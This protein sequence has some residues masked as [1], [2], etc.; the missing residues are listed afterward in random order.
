VYFS[1]EQWDVSFLRTGGKGGPINPVF[2]AGIY[3]GGDGGVSQPGSN[4]DAGSGGGG[5]IAYNVP[6]K[7]A[8]GGNAAAD[9]SS[10][11]GLPGEDAVYLGSG[12]GG[13]GGGIGDNTPPTTS[14]GGNGGNGAGG[15][16]SITFD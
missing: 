5:A 3:E 9:L 8:N 2:P 14:N 16:I 6:Q 4:D 12:G 15:Y 13:G 10:P 1:G 7:G 11:D